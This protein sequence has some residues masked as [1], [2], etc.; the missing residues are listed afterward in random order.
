IDSS[1]RIITTGGGITGTVGPPVRSPMETRRYNSD[2]SLDLSF[3]GTG[4]YN[5]SLTTFP[6]GS[7][8]VALALDQSG[9]IIIAGQVIIDN[10]PTPADVDMIIWRLNVDGTLDT[11]FNGIGYVR[12][13]NAA[14]ELIN[15]LDEGTSVAIDSF[16]RIVV[17]GVSCNNTGFSSCVGGSYQGYSIVVWRYNPDGTQDT[18]FNSGSHFKIVDSNFQYQNAYTTKYNMKLDSQGR[19]V[20]AAGKDIDA[21]G[22]GDGQNIRV[23]R[24]W[25]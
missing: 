9:K 24:L 2:G 3:N 17:A 12:H 23:Y 5:F 1:G 22:A 21:D 7:T 4:F 20:I 25:P 6:E 13:N 19:I 15:P 18:T 16:G 8:G 11:T 10:F 14:G